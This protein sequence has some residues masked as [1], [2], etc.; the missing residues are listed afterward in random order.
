MREITT[1]NFCLPGIVRHNC[2]DNSYFV[3]DGVGKLER[4]WREH[5]ITDEDDAARVIQVGN[6]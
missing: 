5:I 4:I 2:G 6:Q 3:E 1:F